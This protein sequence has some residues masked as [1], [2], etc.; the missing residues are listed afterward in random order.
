MQQLFSQEQQTGYPTND[1]TFKL[2]LEV[3]HE[4][5]HNYRIKY[6][7]FQANGEDLAFFE[8]D[9]GLLSSWQLLQIEGELP[10][11]IPDQTVVTKP[12]DKNNKDLK[13][14]DVEQVTDNRPRRVSHNIRPDQADLS[15][16]VSEE[17]AY[18][19]QNA[20]FNLR[21]YEQDKLVETIHLDISWLLFDDTKIDVRLYYLDHL[22]QKKVR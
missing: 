20:F 18:S 1:C 17:L 22:V 16:K 10:E 6:D 11:T 2:N 21:I 5:G 13:K 9:A 19:F 8:V 15:I 3:K 4:G 7:W 12:G 14:K